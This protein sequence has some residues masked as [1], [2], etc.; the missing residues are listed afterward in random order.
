[1]GQVQS[2]AD[3]IAQ[4][5]VEQGAAAPAVRGG[6]WRTATVDV[7]GSDGTVTTTDGIVARRL[8]TYPAPQVGDQIRVAVSSAGS[9]VADGRLVPTTGDGWTAIALAGT[10]AALG[11]GTDPPPVC[12]ITTDGLLELSGMVRGTA[13][14]IGANAVIGTVPAGLWPSMWVRGIAPTTT[15]Q[16]YARIAIDPS[17]GTITLTNG[18]VAMTATTW[19]QLDPV[20]G[21]AR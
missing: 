17:N 14:A 19:V 10:W 4:L 5:A 15:A 1:M 3:A 11:G 16:N 13:V 9:W 21:R 20:R 2:M 6:D 7:V 12:R 18:S 8:D